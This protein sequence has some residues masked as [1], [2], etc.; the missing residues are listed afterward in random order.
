MK[1]AIDWL[2]I[3]KIAILTLQET[4]L[5]EEVINNLNE[6]YHM[7]KFY[8][9]GLSTSSGGIMFI[10]NEQTDIPQHI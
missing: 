7:L 3:N 2:H 6:K 10:V 8:G 4:H 5:M 1:M 9:S